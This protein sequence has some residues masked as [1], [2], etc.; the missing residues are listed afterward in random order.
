MNQ[1]KN[2]LIVRTDRIGD[3]VLSLPLAAII[4][5]HFPECKVSFLLREYTKPL[6]VNNPNIDE[7]ITLIEENGKPSIAKNIE[8]LKKINMTASGG[9]DVCIVAYPTY[10]IALILFLSNIKTRIGTGYR[11]Y[12][13]L[14][15]KKNYEHRKYGEHH[16]L[17]YNVH[18]LRQLGIDENVT[19]KNVSY[20]ITPSIQDEEKVK[21]DLNEL[22]I[23]FSKPIII[24][25]PGSGGSAVDL[26]IS[27]MK[28]IVNNLSN[29]GVEILITGTT[30]EKELCQSLVVNK[31]IINLAGRYNLSELIALINQCNVM[32]ANST[33]PIHIA[34]A[35]GKNVVGFYPKFTT[36]SA[37]RWGPYTNKKNV[38][39]PDIDCTNCT[40]KQ[41]EE[42]NCMDSIRSDKVAQTVKSILDKIA[43]EK[44]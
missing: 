22:G 17:E 34:A 8:L 26:P 12:S 38:F 37:K 20:G 19:E 11:W 42:L 18:L 6:V 21:K 7:V 29:E 30:A 10:P 23:N 33:G 40:R 35:L 25:H 4:K 3:V 39:T 28:E 15:N 5:K 2:I 13:F 24:V 41:C 44:K 36:A 16:E 1:P 32:I 27:K 31:S 43:S 14:F 9:F